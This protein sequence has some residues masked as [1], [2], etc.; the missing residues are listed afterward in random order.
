MSHPA[1]RPP[2]PQYF[3]TTQWSVVLAANEGT[4]EADAALEQ[5][6]SVYWWPLYAF[7]RRRG[8]EAHDAED[9]TQEFFFRLLAK[10]YLRAVDRSKGKFRSFLLSSLEHFLANEWRNAHTQKR[11]G[12]FSFVSADIESAEQKYLQ[13]PSAGLS[14]EKLFEQQWVT[15]LL[16][17]TVARL[18]D[19]WVASG[20]EGQFENLRIFLTGEKRASSYAI[21]AD[22]LKTTTAA[23]KMAVSRMRKRYGELLREEI[24]NTLSANEEVDE[25]MR[26]LFAALS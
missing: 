18:R 19:E 7:I 10:D 8:Y 16:D 24:G 11:G 4:L 3:V 5:L 20:K 1:E 14:P 6:C 15:T 25:E 2:A 9:L 17:R 26:S 23:L 21:L 13:V 22:Q 12:K